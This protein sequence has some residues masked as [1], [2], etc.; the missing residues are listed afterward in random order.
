M[1][2]VLAFIN[3]SLST[4]NVGDLFIED[5]VKR[6]LVFDRANSIDIDPRKPITQAQLDAINRTEAAVI[7]GT[8]LWYRDMP[9]AGRWR[10]SL[11]D[12]NKIRVPI[13]PFGVGTT[14]HFGEDNGFEGETLA[15]L[16]RIHTSCPVA[17]ARDWR[18]VEALEGAG[19]RNVVMTGCPTLFRT[20]APTWQLHPFQ[21]SRPIVLTVRK[22]QRPNVRTLIRLM[23]QRAIE[24]VVAAQQDGDRF[25]AYSV[26][27]VRRAIPTVYR[28][29]IKPYLE[30]VRECIGAIGWRLHGNMLHLAYGNPAMLFCNCSRGE[31]FCDSFGLP[32]VRCPDHTRL[33]EAQVAEM[34]DRLLDRASYAALPRHYAEFRA[35]MAK[36]LE[37]N[38]LDHR[39]HESAAATATPDP[40][41]VA[42]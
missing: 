40:L 37:A 13:I 32:R 18:T 34:L 39:L 24:P 23:R 7:A 28:Y 6:I 2:R 15:Q 35:S 10:F 36:V 12:L 4:R 27:L 41:L 30:L 3:P 21:E 20:L 42:A 38:G 11:A 31:S 1:A 29:D 16:K 33:A 25:L 19:I 9:R 17:S 5:S 22:G 26:P 8:N 14:R